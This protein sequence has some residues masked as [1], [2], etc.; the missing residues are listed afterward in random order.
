MAV[1]YADVEIRGGDV[2]YCDPPYYGTKQYKAIGAFD[3]E[4]F[5]AYLRGLTER[6]IAWYCSEYTQPQVEC[7]EVGSVTK[8]VLLS[9]QNN[10]LRS[11]ERLFTN[12]HGEERLYSIF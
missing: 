1:D 10:S 4:R 6:G 3:F 11:T 2:V 8:R 5:W 9:A 12:R 7:V